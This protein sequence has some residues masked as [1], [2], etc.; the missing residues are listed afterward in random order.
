M[1]KARY[2]LAIVEAGW[3]SPQLQIQ[4]MPFKWGL[5]IGFGKEWIGIVVGPL[6]VIVW[7]RSCPF[8]ST[9]RIDR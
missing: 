5:A 7:C 1:R 8:E 6:A 3:R 9:W 4:V 2:R